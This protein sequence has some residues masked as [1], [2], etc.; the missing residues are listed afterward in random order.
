MSPLS[1]SI[2]VSSSLVPPSTHE[3]WNINL[4]CHA[5]LIPTEKDRLANIAKT[6]DAIIHVITYD[7]VKRQDQSSFDVLSKVIENNDS[8]LSLELLLGNFCWCKISYFM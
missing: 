2:Q 8:K 7:S 1:S 4:S 3:Q 5:E 6:S